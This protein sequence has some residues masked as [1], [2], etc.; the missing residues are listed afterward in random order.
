MTK[1]KDTRPEPEK[2]TDGNK[3]K[4]PGTEKKTDVFLLEP[5]DVRCFFAAGLLQLV[6]IG[7][8]IQMLFFSWSWFGLASEVA[9]ENPLI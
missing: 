8:M 3:N 4:Q 2:Q 1:P 5:G 9:L 6:Y 7:S